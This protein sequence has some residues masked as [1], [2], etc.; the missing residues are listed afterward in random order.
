MKIKSKIRSLHL[1][2]RTFHSVENI[3]EQ[4]NPMSKGWIN[5]YSAFGKTEFRR[6]M[7]YLDVR[8]VR[9]A[10]RK[11]KS[12]TGKYNQAYD[13]LFALSVKCPSLF[14]HWVMGYTLYPRQSTLRLK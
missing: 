12:L 13:W 1:N 9:W 4:L 5:Y 10:M 6:V 8:I 7:K 3:A 2:R 14:S 11:Y